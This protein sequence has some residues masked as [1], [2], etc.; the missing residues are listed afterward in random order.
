MGVALVSLRTR[1]AGLHR[2]DSQL[3]TYDPTIKT[4]EEQS[5]EEVVEV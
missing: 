2:P 1:F 5:E 3:V 4:E